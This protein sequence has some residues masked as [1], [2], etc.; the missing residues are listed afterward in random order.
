[1]ALLTKSS[2]QNYNDLHMK[3]SRTFH[4]SYKCHAAAVQRQLVVLENAANQNSLQ[5]NKKES[6]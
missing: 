2:Y 3:N 5:I 4:I 6:S 1:M